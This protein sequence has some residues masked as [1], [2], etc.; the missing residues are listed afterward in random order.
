[1]FYSNESHIWITLKNSLNNYRPTSLLPGKN[2]NKS[3]YLNIYFFMVDY[4]KNLTFN[5]ELRQIS[6]RDCRRNFKWP[7]I[8]RGACLIHNGTL[9]NHWLILKEKV[10]LVFIS[11]MV[12]NLPENCRKYARV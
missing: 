11:K 1:M 12:F 10:I 2:Q 5:N 8:Y 6:E 7:F 3:K 9:H 4:T